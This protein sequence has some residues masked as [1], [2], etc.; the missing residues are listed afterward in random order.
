MRLDSVIQPMPD[1]L[2]SGCS[3]YGPECLFDD[4]LIKIQM[5]KILQCFCIMNITI[6]H[7]MTNWESV[8]FGNR[9][10]DLDQRTAFRQ[11]R[12][13]VRVDWAPEAGRKLLHPLSVHWTMKTPGLCARQPPCRHTVYVAEPPCR[14]CVDFQLPISRSG[15]RLWFFVWSSF[16]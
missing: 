4:I 6:I 8:I 11:D 14:Q 12:F 7:L 16:M 2:K 3:F 10:S 5:N 1:R 13:L 9:Q 15:C